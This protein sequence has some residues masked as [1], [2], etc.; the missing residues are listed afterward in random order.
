MRKTKVAIAVIAILAVLAVANYAFRMDPTQLAA[1]GV[2]RDPHSHDQVHEQAE[3]SQN[4]APLEPLGPQGAPVRIEVFYPRAEIYHT[5]YEPLIQAIYEDYQ[6]HLRIEPRDLSDP[7]VHKEAM[8]LPLKGAPGLSV[9]GEVIT[10]V[11]GAGVDGIVAL[12]GGPG[13]RSWS[14]GMLRKVIEQD[15]KAKGVQFTPPPSSIEAGPQHDHEHEH[16]HGH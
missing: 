3:E 2:G 7:A 10:Q 11:E 9:N 4:L 15:L 12:R 1:R 16:E 5:D 8:E 6:P 14:P 13:D